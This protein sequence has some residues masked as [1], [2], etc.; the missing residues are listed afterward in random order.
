[1]PERISDHLFPDRVAPASPG[2]PVDLWIYS[3]LPKHGWVSRSPGDLA[4]AEHPGSAIQHGAQL[5]E[6]MR[7]EETA[8]EGYQF[9]YGLRAWDAQFTVRH[10][11]LSAL[12]SL[13]PAGA[14]F[15]QADTSGKVG[16]CP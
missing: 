15:R 10:P 3:V 4:R 6:L 1:M 13:H 7:V 11:S 14:S 9:R 2:D 16:E 12:A 5:Y 8:Q